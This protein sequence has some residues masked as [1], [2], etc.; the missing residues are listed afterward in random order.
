MSAPETRE[1]SQLALR[2]AVLGVAEDNAKN[3]Y[4]AARRAAAPAFAAARADGVKQVALMLPGGVEAG[5]IAIKAGGTTTDVDED[6]MFDLIAPVL[7]SEV[8]DYALP[9]AELD[10][11]VV[12]LLAEHA[13]DLLE[14]RVKPGALSDE[15]LVKILAAHAPDLLGQRL[16]REFRAEMGKHIAK[17]EGKIPHPDT[18]DLMPVATITHHPPTGEFSWTGKNKY[19][20]WVREALESGRLVITPSGDV[21]ASIPGETVAPDALESGEGAA[22]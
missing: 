1:L 9:G 19:L 5:T 3:A 4:T 13:A 20:D 17:H 10:A 16:T 21:V 15:R 18:G 6:K 8:E 7:P 11:R 2:V 22:A 14:L 12:T